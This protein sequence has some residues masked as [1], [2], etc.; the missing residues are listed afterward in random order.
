MDCGLTV[1]SG[2]LAQLNRTPGISGAMVGLVL[3]FWMS[4]E[5]LFIVMLALLPYLLPLAGIHL[6][7]REIPQPTMN[8]MVVVV[9]YPLFHPRLCIVDCVKYPRV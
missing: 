5:Q 3:P 4:K 8:P 6:L 9:V 1:P 2:S 7:W